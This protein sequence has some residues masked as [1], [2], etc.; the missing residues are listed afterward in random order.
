MK[1]NRMIVGYIAILLLVNMAVA[2]DQKGARKRLVG[3]W[4][5]NVAQSTW[6]K[7]PAPKESTLVVLQDNAMGL[8]WTGSGVSAEGDSF[9]FSF[10]GVVDRKDYPM[11]SPNNEAVIG[12]TRAYSSIDGTLRAIDKKN[13]SVLQSSTTTVSHDGRT[14]TIKFVSSDSGATWRE[15]WTESSKTAP[16]SVM[17]WC[18]RSLA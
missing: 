15:C 17:A 10:D 8:K 2:S 5:L 7:V 11:K 1:R 18:L 4:K 3:T 13:S 6:G 14:M 12:F 16:F 9:S